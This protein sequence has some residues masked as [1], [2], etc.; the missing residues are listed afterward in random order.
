MPHSGWMRIRKP[1]CTRGP[2]DEPQ[3]AKP[4]LAV[5]GATGAVGG[6]MLDLL[7]TRDDVG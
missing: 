3:A 1:S 2:A 6:V 5:V 4:T 7:S